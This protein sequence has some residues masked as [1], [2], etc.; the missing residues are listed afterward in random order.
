MRIMSFPAKLR[1]ARMLRCPA[2]AGSG[3][4]FVGSADTLPTPDHMLADICAAREDERGGRGAL[5]V[6]AEPDRNRGKGAIAS[7]EGSS[8]P[9]SGRERPRK[10]IH[11]DMDA[12]Y[13]S[14]EQRDD[15][16][17]RGKPVA[18]GGSRERGVVAAASYEARKFGVRSAMPSVTARRKCPDLIFVK[19]RFD[20]YKEVS[21]QVR[22]I[23]AEHTAIVEPLSLDEAYLDVTESLQ[24]I[25]SAVEIAGR[26]RAKIRAETQLTASAG[27]SY[28]K[29]LAKLASD[30]RKPDGLFVITPAMGPSFV[31][32]LPVERFHGVGPATAAKMKELGIFTAFDLRAK[33]EAFLLKHFGKAGRHFYCICRGID[34]RPVLPNRIRKSVG[35]EN[36]FSRDLTGLDDMRAELD[37]LVDKVWAYCD[38]TGTRGRTVTL[39]VKFADFQIITRSRSRLVAISDRSTLASIS[40]EMLAALFPMRKGVRLIGV[41][42][43]SL[44]ADSAEVDPQMTLA[45]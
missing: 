20:V 35:A 30:Y 24:G 29:F 7:A 11:V 1:V 3:R 4:T 28:N 5:I 42:L 31:E 18:V 26:I 2:S 12:F 40:A 23:F 34:H 33:D 39:K 21:L 16:G 45:L 14:V 44:C 8:D 22:A 43:S 32:A 36:T 38:G 37:P 27:V 10:I 19:P 41:S 25:V 6:M 17:L 15:P 13:A 9:E